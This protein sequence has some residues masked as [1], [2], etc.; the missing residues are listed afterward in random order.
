MRPDRE[1]PEPLSDLESRP[2]L[3]EL[4][5]EIQGCRR[6]AGM[7]PFEPRPVLRPKPSARI[8]IIGQAPSATVHATGIP[9]NDASGVRLR[10]WLGVEAE[11]FYGDPAIA[12]MPMGF[13]Y[14]GKGKSGDLPPRGECAPSWHQRLWKNMPDL[15]LVLLVGAYAQRHYLGRNKPLTETVRSWRD[16][17]APFFPLPH[18]SPRNFGWFMANPWFE[19]EVIPALGERADRLLTKAMA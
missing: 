1:I 19:A 2:D 12:I 4:V 6:C 9:W 3:D 5:A 14:P 13:C 16:T 11:V 18:P 7:L 17:P 8:L 15:E 10:R